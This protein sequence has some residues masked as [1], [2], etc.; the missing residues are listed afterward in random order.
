MPKLIP[1]TN[2]DNESDSDDED[3]EEDS[4]SNKGPVTGRTSSGRAVQA[5]I[6]YRDQEIG[7]SPTSSAWTSTMLI[8]KRSLLEQQSTQEHGSQC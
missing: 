5:P 7:A 1:Q 2:D 8:S 4:E 3:D 6:R